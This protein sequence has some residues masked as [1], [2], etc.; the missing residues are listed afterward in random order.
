MPASED[1]TRGTAPTE[2]AWFPPLAL[3]LPLAVIALLMLSP[4]FLEHAAWE[5]LIHS[6]LGI[7]ELFTVAALLPTSAL[8]AMLAI[9][10]G[11]AIPTWLRVCFG[12]LALGCIYFAG[13]EASWGQHVL[14]FTP[15]Q[16]VAE[17]NLQGE[18][19]L[20]NID[21]PAH[22]LLNELPRFCAAMF[23]LIVGAL[24]PLRLG[25]RRL[26]TDAPKVWWYWLTPH[27]SVVLVGLCAAFASV[28]HRIVE[29]LGMDVQGTWPYY[30][31]YEPSDEA[32]E[33][34]IAI[35]LYLVAL[36]AYMRLRRIKRQPVPAE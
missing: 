14:G 27:V 20:H 18:F 32:K 16:E 12:L 23:C 29:E 24:M 35:T 13:E 4:V 22:D 34:Y 28:P 10:G 25:K 17:N 3:A 5:R 15:P 30:A 6:E 19:N 11:G 8:Y 36:S 33:T 31:L 7:L 1:L 26:S 2:P 21:G 9:R